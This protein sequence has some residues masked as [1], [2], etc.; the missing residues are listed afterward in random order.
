MKAR[1][2]DVPTPQEAVVDI[3]PATTGGRHSIQRIAVTGVVVAMVAALGWAGSTTLP[4]HAAAIGSAPTTSPSTTTTA[5]ARSTTTTTPAAGSTTTI[6][7]TTTLVHPAT[8]SQD[9]CDS[10][11]GYLDGVRQIAVSLTDPV[12]L[13]TLVGSATSAV[14]QS[15]PIAP[16][17]ALSDVTYLSSVLTAFS[18]ALQVGSYDITR[19]PQDQLTKFQSPQM[20]DTLARIQTYLAKAC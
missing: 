10:A 5:P 14:A 19:V 16:T 6:A 1:R 13:Q 8:P 3:E 2:D 15:L 7:T 4:V 12:K 9:Y 17:P 11:R 18:G 20:L